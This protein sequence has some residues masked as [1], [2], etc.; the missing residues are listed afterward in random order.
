M[1]RFSVYS[2]LQLLGIAALMA[3][4]CSRAGKSEAGTAD[5]QA[6]GQDLLGPLLADHVIIEGVLDF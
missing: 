4:S 1:A 6:T 2:S 5:Q 3:I